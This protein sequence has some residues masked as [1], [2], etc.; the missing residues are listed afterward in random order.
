MTAEGAVGEENLTLRD[1]PGRR[2]D[3]AKSLR[4]AL[5]FLISVATPASVGLSEKEVNR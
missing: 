4:G 3:C 5:D 1:R 2:S